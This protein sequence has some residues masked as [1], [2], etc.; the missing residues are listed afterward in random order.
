[1]NKYRRVLHTA[2]MCPARSACRKLLH[3]L[4]NLAVHQ[5]HDEHMHLLFHGIVSK[6]RYFIAWKLFA[7]GFLPA[8]EGRGCGLVWE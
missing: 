2:G 4:Q 6:F 5:K 3:L 1:M 7:V 8:R